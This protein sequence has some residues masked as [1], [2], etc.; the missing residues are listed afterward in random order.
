MVLNGLIKYVI[1]CDV[2][3]SNVS[4]ASVTLD[5]GGHDC[6]YGKNVLLMRE[7]E[8]NGQIDCP[9]SPHLSIGW[10]SIPFDLLISADLQNLLIWSRVQDAQR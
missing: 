8:I 7:M 2:F 3:K 1:F 6:S 4:I 5:G 9:R 10:S